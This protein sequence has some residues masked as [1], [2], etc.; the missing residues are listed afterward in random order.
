MRYVEFDFRRW[1][2]LVCLRF[3][4]LR[5]SLILFCTDSLI[6]TPLLCSADTSFSCSIREVTIIASLRPKVLPSLLVP[7]MSCLA[8]MAVL[9]AESHLVVNSRNVQPRQK[10]PV[11]WKSGHAPTGVLSAERGKFHPSNNRPKTL[12]SA[13]TIAFVSTSS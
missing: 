8:P 1:M 10:W 3:Y 11:P 5:L 7:R 4:V 9:W 2:R 12:A 6:L 13:K